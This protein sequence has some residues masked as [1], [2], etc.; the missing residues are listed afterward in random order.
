[1]CLRCVGFV[2]ICQC[3]QSEGERGKNGSIGAGPDKGKIRDDSR[4]IPWGRRQEIE[5][6][7][8]FQIL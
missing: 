7:N 8:C 2:K 1:M 3:L 5:A 4:I 6:S